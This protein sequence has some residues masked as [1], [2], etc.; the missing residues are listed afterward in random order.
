MGKNLKD[1]ISFRKNKDIFW[2]T[3]EPFCV[4]WYV[5]EIHRLID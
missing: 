2:K 3:L 1:E 5:L 4:L